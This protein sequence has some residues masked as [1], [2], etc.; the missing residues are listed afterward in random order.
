M[1]YIIESEFVCFFSYKH[2]RNEVLEG[3]E[4]IVTYF[5]GYSRFQRCLL[6]FSFMHHFFSCL[7]LH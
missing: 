1:E 5:L 2:I 6:R 4:E 7:L 3:I